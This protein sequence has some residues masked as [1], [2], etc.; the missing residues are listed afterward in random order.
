MMTF[1]WIL[2]GVAIVLGSAF[3]AAQQGSRGGE[4]TRYAAD[5]GSTKYAPLDQINKDNVTRLRV[6][7]RRP[8]V[9]LS[10][11]AR[12][13]D[14]SHS[15]NYRATPLMIG[16]VLFTPNGIGLVEA[17][18]PSTGQTL[19]VQKPFPDELDQGLRGDSAR[20]VGYWA[21]GRRPADLCGLSGAFVPF[22]KTKAERQAAN[23][24]RP[25]FEE[26]YGD[27]AGFVKAVEAAT[28][29]LV[30][31]RFLLQEDADRYVQAA[32]EGAGA[33]QIESQ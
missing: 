29:A 11:S 15:N 24:P 10:V 8:A 30:T 3:V 13:P 25:S 6:A 17:F 27:Q 2:F 4:W 26:R 33:L 23:D 5:S 22:A 32:R 20:G 12:K 9:D 7:W 31:E 18:H 21:D 28:R 19:W 16:G 14:F 1:R